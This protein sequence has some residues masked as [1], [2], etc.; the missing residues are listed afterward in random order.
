MCSIEMQPTW[1]MVGVPPLPWATSTRPGGGHLI[2]W[3]MKLVVEFP[4]GATVL[5]PSSLVVHSN[6]R[7]QEGEECMSFAQYAAGGLFRWVDNGF[8]TSEAFKRVDPIGKK[9]VDEVAAHRW[10]H[11]ID[12]FST[13]QALK[14]LSL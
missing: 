2:L 6:T 3:D 1:H 11:G 13:I 7:L 10:Q 12:L 4:P 14:R 8:Q 5:I 9:R